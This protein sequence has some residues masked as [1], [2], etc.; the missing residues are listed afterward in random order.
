MH[1][2]LLVFAL[3]CCVFTA[4]EIP[5]LHFSPPKG[6]HSRKGRIQASLLSPRYRRLLT[7]TKDP[8]SQEY[9]PTM[10]ECIIFPL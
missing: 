5:S 10:A 2:S 3:R 1:C 8:L 6:L 7:S 9:F 4:C